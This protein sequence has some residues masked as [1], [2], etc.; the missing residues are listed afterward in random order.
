MVPQSVSGITSAGLAQ[1][2][3]WSTIKGAIAIT[4]TGLFDDAG[5]PRCWQMKG[6]ISGAAGASPQLH[7]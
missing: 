5:R 2:L 6:K 3:P 4:A 1:Q 7:R